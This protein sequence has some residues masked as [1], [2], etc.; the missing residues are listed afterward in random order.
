MQMQNHV[1]AARPAPHRLNR[2]PADHEID[3]DDA[4]TQLLCEF[5]TLI[6]VLHR[7]GRHVQVV[8]FDFTRFRLRAIH[9]L[10]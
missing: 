9:R 8:A 4:G 3:H 5:G 6:H 1:V 10:H 7:A 2:R